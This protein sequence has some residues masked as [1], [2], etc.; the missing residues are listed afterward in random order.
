MGEDQ[1]FQGT[2]LDGGD[3]G[4]IGDYPADQCSY[5]VV[6][7]T[8]CKCLVTKEA[9]CNQRAHRTIGFDFPAIKRSVALHRHRPGCP[10]GAIPSMEVAIRSLAGLFLQG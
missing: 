4:A 5:V 3:T 6:F 7:A 8:F 9:I 1:K 10:D 2:G